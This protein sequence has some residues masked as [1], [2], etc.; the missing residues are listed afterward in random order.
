MRIEESESGRLTE[1]SRD[2]RTGSAEGSTPGIMCEGE[3]ASCSTSSAKSESVRS[4]FH[5]SRKEA[6]TEVVLRVLVERELSDG[7][8][9]EL[10]VRPDLG[11]IEDVVSECLSLG[12][13]HR[14]DA[15]SPRRVLL[16]LNGLEEI[17]R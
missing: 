16:S 14:L 10:G 5:T 7:S 2:W 13:G 12:D 17:L 11:E 3:K 9:R 1:K 6:R 15:E 4:N 8:E